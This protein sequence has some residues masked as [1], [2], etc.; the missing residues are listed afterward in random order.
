MLSAM[1][2]LETREYRMPSVPLIYIRD[3]NGIKTSPTQIIVP[4]SFY[5]L[6]QIV[7]VHITGI[8]FIAHANDATCA[9]SG[10]IL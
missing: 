9:F 3:T 7:E 10:L 4:N 1:M 8:A 6:S 5:Q 2:S